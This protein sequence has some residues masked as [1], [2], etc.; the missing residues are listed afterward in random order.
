MLGVPPG[1]LRRPAVAPPALVAAAAAA[2]VW[3]PSVPIPDVSFGIRV[4]AVVTDVQPPRAMIA[5]PDGREQV[6]S[7]GAMLPEIGVVV[8]AIGRNAV[9]IARV[10]PNGFYARVDT[11]TIA[12]LAPP[13]AG[14]QPIADR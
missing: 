11:D 4:I 2:P 8:L 9:Q 7:P 6:V 14:P 3:D 5:L 1:A 10:T 12:V 13:S